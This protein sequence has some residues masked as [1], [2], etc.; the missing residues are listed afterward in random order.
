MSIAFGGTEDWLIRDDVNCCQH[1]N[2]HSDVSAVSAIKAGVKLTGKRW[3]NVPVVAGWNNGN[4][5]PL[6]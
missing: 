1:K 2:K 6:Y 5:C 4:P 3:T